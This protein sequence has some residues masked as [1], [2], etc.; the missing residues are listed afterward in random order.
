VIRFV[1]I[2]LI[3]ASIGGSSAQCQP[4]PQSTAPTVQP[5]RKGEG[6]GHVH[7]D[8]PTA[9]A[10]DSRSNGRWM[11]YAVGEEGTRYFVTCWR[12]SNQAT[13]REVDIDARTYRA[14][15]RNPDTGSIPCPR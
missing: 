11:V 14:Y 9:P 3:A 12:N 10:P 4:G 1:A 2:P 7:P 15:L 13:F 5:A 6:I 8:Y